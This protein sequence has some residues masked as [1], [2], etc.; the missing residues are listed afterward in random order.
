MGKTLKVILVK[1]YFSYYN[2]IKDWRDEVNF[3][4]SHS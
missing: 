2:D 3:L 4:K 1:L